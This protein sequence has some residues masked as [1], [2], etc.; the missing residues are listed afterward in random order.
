MVSQ[1][2]P[3][4]VICNSLPLSLFLSLALCCLIDTIARLL[5]NTTSNNTWLEET[6]SSSNKSFHRDLYDIVIQT[7][8][9]VV[10]LSTGK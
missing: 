3:K 1:S 10:K 7:A 2:M 9:N 6:L 8:N 4:H 5:D